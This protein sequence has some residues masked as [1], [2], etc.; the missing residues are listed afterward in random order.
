MQERGVYDLY[1]AFAE[2]LNNIR[3]M[4]MC[5][6]LPSNLMGIF[7]ISAALMMQL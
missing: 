6:F 3:K 1:L 4:E 5:V 7:M 2:R